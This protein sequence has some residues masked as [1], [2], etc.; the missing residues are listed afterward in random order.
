[1]SSF[2][3]EFA[4]PPPLPN[5]LIPFPDE[6]LAGFAMRIAAHHGFN[7]MYEFLR[8]IGSKFTT[9]GL[10]TLH[11][12]H[13]GLA[14]Y[15][16]LSAVE[17]RRMCSPV[18]SDG[19][20]VGQSTY[21]D[22][23]MVW[24]RKVCPLCIAEAAYHR[25]FW[26][27]TL[28]T[29]CPSHRA[30]L[31]RNC[32]RCG[33]ALNWRMGPLTHCSSPKCSADLR[34]VEVTLVPEAEMAGVRGLHRLVSGG[35]EFAVPIADLSVGDQ[36]L[37]AFHLG[38]MATKRR[39]F[40]RPQD[41][42]KE[43]PDQVHIVLEA[44][45]RMASGWPGSFHEYLDRRT[46]APGGRGRYG[47]R[48]NFGSLRAWLARRDEPFARLIDAELTAYM[49]S[50]PELATRAPAIASAR[51]AAPLEQRAI[52]I[53]G[54]CDMLGV[55][56]NVMHRFAEKHDLYLLRPT[57]QGAPA[58]LRADRVH[59]LKAELARLLTKKDVGRL[60]GSAK[61]T[62]NKLRKAGLLPTEPDPGDPDGV[63]YPVAGVESLL[64]DL[65]GRVTPFER[66]VVELVGMTTITR[67]VSRS[68]YDVCDVI[69]A[70]R[71]GKLTPRGLRSGARGVHRFLFDQGEVSAFVA[72]ITAKRRRTLS[73]SE[74]STLLGVKQEVA[75]HWVR[76]GLLVTV[77]MTERGESGRRVTNEALSAFR[78]DYVTA[79]EYQE[80]RG[81]GRRWG[82]STL[83]EH[84]VQPIS[85]PSVDG[86]RQYLFRRADVGGIK[87]AKLAQ[88]D[89]R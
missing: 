67:Q 10:A 76:T 43:Y 86:A 48:K 6:S 38:G 59:S 85:G 46:A 15:L 65:E 13:P 71:A 64:S 62:V 11:S 88:G 54:A 66:H 47:I 27:L 29:V 37:L 82:A 55:G 3:P 68:G 80:T 72:E 8:P 14:R 34:D 53:V 42:A 35:Q 4:D 50:R 19:L 79:T 70:V 87:G 9:V 83:L 44:G 45:W 32:H 23:L 24:E 63:L 40:S 51:A 2:E 21:P 78:R 57:G 7:N 74:A 20:G 12:G 89:M 77:K 31:I 81:L 1:M 61:R 60:L 30:P 58:L 17:V 39:K 26:D 33:H 56:L 84:G 5:G 75:Y 73:V 36:I 28:A 16:G 52:T 25:S 22:L 69:Q 41:F 18:N 49:I